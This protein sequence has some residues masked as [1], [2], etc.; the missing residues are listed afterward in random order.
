MTHHLAVWGNSIWLAMS[1]WGAN[2]LFEKLKLGFMFILEVAEATKPRIVPSGS[3][4]RDTG[5]PDLHASEV[6]NNVI[7]DNTELPSPNAVIAVGAAA[8]ITTALGLYLTIDAIYNV[9][10]SPASSISPIYATVVLAL[11]IVLDIIAFHASLW[12][13]HTLITAART[14]EMEILSVDR[15]K[16][17][18]LSTRAY[19]VQ[20]A[21]QLMH[22]SRTYL[23]L[24]EAIVA[25]RQLLAPSPAKITVG[26]KEF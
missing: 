4:L 26:S 5:L 21:S 19:D 14:A 17:D 1:T 15:D 9:F 18:E 7:R 3:G 2:K 10:F 11:T 22:N 13:M 23:D 25:A 8:G 20:G 6:F 16:L 24:A 12:T